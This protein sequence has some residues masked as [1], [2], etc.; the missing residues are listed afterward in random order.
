MGNKRFMEY[1]VPV[2]IIAMAMAAILFASGCAAT[3]D[4]MDT[5]M[6]GQPAS[7]RNQ[8]R[9]TANT[10][11]EILKAVQENGT[12][13]EKK[14]ATE[15]YDRI[16]K[17]ADAYGDGGIVELAAVLMM[18]SGI[19][20]V[21]GL[22]AALKFWLG[23]KAQAKAMTQTTIG[24]KQALADLPKVHSDEVKAVLDKA[25]DVSTKK[26]VGEIKAEL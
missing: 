21:T 17:G 19:T 6:T 2:A 15:H 26:I 10:V 14:W 25:Q 23:K 4:G 7:V 24:L 12:P 9:E 8:Q 1:V 3:L 18:G 22:G 11:K 16:E 20:G 5:L 13:E